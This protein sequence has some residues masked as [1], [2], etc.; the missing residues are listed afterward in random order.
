MKFNIASR[1]PAATTNYMGGKAF[2]LSA[3][4]EL[5]TAVVSSML[6]DSYYEK[7]DDRLARIQKLVPQVAPEFVAKLAIYTREQM[8][9]RSVPLVLIGELA[10]VHRGDNL[11]SHTIERVVSRPDEITEL[12]AYYQLTNQRTDTKK[13]GKLSKQIQKGLAMSFNRFDGYQFAKYN[14]NASVTLKD[15]LFLVHP[16]AKDEAQQELFNQIAKD[17]LP[18]PYTWETELSQ[19]GQRAFASETEKQQAKAAKWEELVLS[20]KV[21]Y[22]A[23]LRNLRNIV[24]QGTDVALTGALKQ[25]ADKNKVL[26]SKQLPFRFLSAYAEI[27][28]LTEKNP[29][30]ESEKTK[31][32]AALKAIEQA[33]VFATDNI[34]VAAGKTLIL[35]DNS[36]SMFGDMGGKSVVSAMSRRTTADIA[37]LFAVLYW[38]RAEDTLVGL[39][40]DNL[41]MP[42]LNR[43]HSVFENFKTINAEA[44]KCGPSTEQ[45][46]FDMMEM[47]L[48]KKQKVDRIIIFSDCQVGSKCNW[49]DKKRRA[50]NDFNKLFQAYRQINP[51]VVTYSVDLKGY[52]NT[53][54]DEGVMTVAGWSEK[55]FDM[56]V[57]LEEKESVIAS[58]NDIEL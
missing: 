27:E 35:S 56:M 55:I 14:R 28:A 41:V 31:I 18:V 54:F 20:G 47:L 6:Q 37:N 45:G 9:L 5:Y 16:K 19:L 25:I 36:G 34:P 57:S 24:T 49:F 38:L 48:E 23:L 33:V 21:G 15:A 58:I 22:M 52:G 2:R 39:F 8:H 32:N 3:E 51:S 12:L 43:K 50:G 29:M 42:S 40:G 4:M 17:S 44:K 53:L 30:F 10:K 26:R 46:I 7:A 1:Q 11:V 13:L